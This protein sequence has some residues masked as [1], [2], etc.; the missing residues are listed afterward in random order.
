VDP[1]DATNA[2]NAQDLID[3]ILSLSV[4]TFVGEGGGDDISGHRGQDV[5]FGDALNTDW[6]IIEQGLL[7]EVSLG[8]NAD[9]Y[10]YLEQNVAG[11]GRKETTEH[12]L[13]NQVILAE[14]DQV[15]VLRAGDDTLRGGAQN[16]VIYAQGG[17]DIVDG[18]LG[19]DLINPGSA[20]IFA[21]D[22]LLLAP[23]EKGNIV[24]GGG[25][26]TA[27]TFVFTVPDLSRL[28]TKTRITDWEPEFDLLVFS[29]LIDGGNSGVANG[30]ADKEDLTGDNGIFSAL[31]FAS[32]EGGTIV[33]FQQQ[34]ASIPSSSIVFVGIT[35]TSLEGLVADT[36][37]I[38]YQLDPV[39]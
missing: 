18:G 37:Q 21:E 10:V 35:A 11:W 19:N 29:D 28:G 9:V 39:V 20:D 31:D 2:E 26:D 16:D 7:G 34:G 24:T 27:D 8:S 25:E 13:A 30:E 38:Q 4:V 6:F 1:N 12:I 23:E 3:E 32:G 5:I 33:T 15:N 22:Q 36:N 14:E 17:N